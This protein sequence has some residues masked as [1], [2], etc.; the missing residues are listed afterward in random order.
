MARKKKKPAPT[1]PNPAL[2]PFEYL[3]ARAL[4]NKLFA[5]VDVAGESVL[6]LTEA[7]T[8]VEF[9]EIASLADD[10]VIAF[11]TSHEAGLDFAR[12][13][14]KAGVHACPI[15]GRMFHEFWRRTES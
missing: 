8:N 1:A 5:F 10:Q 2:L 7:R 4:D 14:F 13:L 12:Q 15:P 9:Q 3:E 11:A 6:V